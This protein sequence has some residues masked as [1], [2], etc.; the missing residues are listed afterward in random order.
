MIDINFDTKKRLGILSGDHFNEIR[1][2][3]MKLIK[4]QKKKK[5]V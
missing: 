3:L 4:P 1:E 5:E 2:N